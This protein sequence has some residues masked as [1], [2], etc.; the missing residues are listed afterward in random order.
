V[1]T[2]PQ[3][4]TCKRTTCRSSTALCVA[5][6][7]KKTPVTGRDMQKWRGGTSRYMRQ[8]TSWDYKL[9]LTLRCI[10]QRPV[11]VGTLFSFR[12]RFSSIQDEDVLNRTCISR[13]QCSVARAARSPG[14]LVWLMRFAVDA[15]PSLARHLFHCRHHQKQLIRRTM[16]SWSWRRITGRCAA[17]G[18]NYATTTNMNNAFGCDLNQ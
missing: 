16:S 14:Q 7:G 4:R 2:I 5:S 8:F 9:L 12:R 18:F 13:S 6:C 10:E 11:G 17:R 15:S 3:R 1:T